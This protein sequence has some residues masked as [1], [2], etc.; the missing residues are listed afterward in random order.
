[1]SRKIITMHRLTW[2][3]PYGYDYH[4]YGYRYN[5]YLI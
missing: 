3:H 5:S 4:G 2:W 1:M